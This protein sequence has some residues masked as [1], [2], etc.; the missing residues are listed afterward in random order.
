MLSGISWST[1]LTTIAAILICYYLIVII[2]YYRAEVASFLNHR[3]VISSESFNAPEKYPVDNTLAELESMVNKIDDILENSGKDTQKEELLEQFNP[4]LDGF[5]GLT[6]P[7]WRVALYNHIISKS[8]EQCG[9]TISEE[10]LD[11]RG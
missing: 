11:R 2:L 9:V 1:Y 6:V 5:A 7:A 4:I 10:E 8:A 3:S